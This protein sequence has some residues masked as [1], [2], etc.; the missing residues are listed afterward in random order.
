MKKLFKKLH[1]IALVLVAAGTASAQDPDFDRSGG[2]AYQDKP[3]EYN[4]HY[5]K[6]KYG[7]MFTRKDFGLYLGLNTFYKPQDMPELKDFPSRFVALQW[8]KNHRLI[9]GSQVDVAL[10]T[11][12]EV[13]WNNFMLKKDVQFVDLGNTSDVGI[14]DKTYE[15]VKLVN[16]TLSIPVML[17][18]GFKESNFR[19]GLGGYGGVRIGSYQKFSDGSRERFKEREDFNLRKFNYGLM[20]EAGKG[21]CRVFVKY[22]ILP[23]FNDNN[24]INANTISFGLRL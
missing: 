24:P 23:L 22:D 9:T 7:N 5:Q 13:G 1:V 17:Q 11:G 2:T 6:R 20:A 14:T 8:R 3:K 18:F 16:S 19:I 21:D 4:N 15:K 12:L 10:G